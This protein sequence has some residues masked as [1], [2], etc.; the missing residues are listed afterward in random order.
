MLK[1]P[2][3]V[4]REIPEKE[5]I[6]E[7]ESGKVSIYTGGKKLTTLE[8]PEY[9][10]RCLVAIDVMV[11]VINSGYSSALTRVYNKAGE[12]TTTSDEELQKPIS[13]IIYVIDEI[14]L[15]KKLETKLLNC[16]QNVID[17]ENPSVDDAIKVGFD[18]I[19]KHYLENI[20]DD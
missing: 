13:K 12:E 6:Y 4:I 5:Y 11:R 10:I 14:K 17:G 20:N 9:A 3:N 1:I 2:V 16:V 7:L 18:V 19:R 8:A 15:G